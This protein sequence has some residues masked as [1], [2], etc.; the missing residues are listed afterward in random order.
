[1]FKYQFKSSRLRLTSD[2]LKFEQVLFLSQPLHLPPLD[3]IMKYIMVPIFFLP[4]LVLMKY[5]EEVRTFFL[6]GWRTEVVNLQL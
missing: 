3:R 6:G 5:Y 1:M 2:G 4:Y